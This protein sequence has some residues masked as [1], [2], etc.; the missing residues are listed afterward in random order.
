MLNHKRKKLLS[1]KKSYSINKFENKY[2]K[3]LRLLRLYLFFVSAI[4]LCF[5]N[6]GNIGDNKN[7]DIY[8]TTNGFALSLNT[9]LQAQEASRI[10][11]K[12]IGGKSSDFSQILKEEASTQIKIMRVL[13]HSA[14]IHYLEQKLKDYFFLFGVANPYQQESLQMMAHVQYKLGNYKRAYFLAKES[15]EFDKTTQEA[16]RAYFLL[17]QINERQGNISKANAIF[18]KI[19][20]N[21]TW[22]TIRSSACQASN[23]LNIRK[24]KSSKKK[25]II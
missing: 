25:K 20:E 7:N 1:Y 6:T 8:S 18:K 13:I 11:K 23:R 3:T 12:N 2:S 22:E 9:N 17:G 14:S 19:C 4:L 24:K 21:K 16:Q 15:Y 5:I 10:I